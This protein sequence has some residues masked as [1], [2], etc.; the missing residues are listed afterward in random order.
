MRQSVKLIAIHYQVTFYIMKLLCDH[1]N[2]N[3]KLWIITD[4]TQFSKRIIL[5]TETYDYILKA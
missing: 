2:V 5:K 4:V 3:Q 1:I